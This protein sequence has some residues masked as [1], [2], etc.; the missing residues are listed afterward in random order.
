MNIVG[1]ANDLLYSSLLANC[2]VLSG[3]MKMHIENDFKAQSLFFHETK[4]IINAPFYDLKHWRKTG[5]IVYLKD[6]K[7]SKK[8]G[9]PY[10]V[11]AR[12]HGRT[13]YAEWVNSLG[14]FGKPNKSKGWVNR[15]CMAMAVALAS[16]LSEEGYEAEINYLLGD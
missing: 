13:S 2:P 6:T 8:T 11:M 9:K 1:M 16:K 10:S 12:I 14:A 15:S 5:Q 7:I 4:L 3:N